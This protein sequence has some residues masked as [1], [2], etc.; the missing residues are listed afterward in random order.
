VA[1]LGYKGHSPP[2]SEAGSNEA[3]ASL[4]RLV[5][6]GQGEISFQGLPSGFGWSGQSLE[7]EISDSA[8]FLRQVLPNYQVRAYVKAEDGPT[9]DLISAVGKKLPDIRIIS[10]SYLA[11]ARPGQAPELHELAAAADGTVYFP[12]VTYSKTADGCLK[13]DLASVITTHGL[14]SH[15]IRADEIAGQPQADPDWASLH[16]SYGELFSY[17][18]Q[19]YPWLEND[20][21]STGAAK[22]EQASNLDVY[23]EASNGQIRL[24]AGNGAANPTLLLVTSQTVTGGSGCTWEKVDS[25]RYLV[26][27]QAKTAVLEVE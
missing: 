19:S 6:R 4:S 22:L 2:G 8:A 14:V 20:T 18:G 5:L 15:A 23:Y 12:R 7:P 1:Y 13:F 16:R 17:I 11:D 26:T 21:I 27:M 3:F 24:A 10:G 25:V 9:D